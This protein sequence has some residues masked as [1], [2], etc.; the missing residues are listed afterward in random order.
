[1]EKE[2]KKNGIWH[3]VNIPKTPEQKETAERL[4]HTLLVTS[5]W[6]KASTGQKQCSYIHFGGHYTP[7]SLVISKPGIAHV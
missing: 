2:E 5:Y 3:E 7:R 6:M 1:M 4:N